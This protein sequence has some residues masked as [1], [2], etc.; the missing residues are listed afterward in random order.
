[1]MSSTQLKLLFYKV[2]YIFL[3][4]S[5]TLVSFNVHGQMSN[6]ADALND[7]N[8]YY[9]TS[10]ITVSNLN[11]TGNTDGCVAG[12]IST[13]A[14]N[15]F[16]DRIK[17]FRRLVGVS[18]NV[19][20]DNTKNNK[21]QEAALIM[22]ANNSL[23]HFPP[24]SWDCYNADG[25]EAAGK[26]NLH[27][28][29]IS[30]FNPINSYISDH[31]TG[32]E[33]VGHRR[34]IFYSKATE[35]GIGQ[36]TTANSMWVIQDSSTPA[37]Y[38][39]YIA[40]PPNG[41]IPNHL[42]FERWSFGIPN[43]NFSNASVRVK[44]QNNNELDVDIIY[45]SGPIYADNTIVF[46]P[47]GII[48]NSMDDIEYEITISNIAGASS[49][50]YTYTTRLFD[51]QIDQLDGSCN[52]SDGP[53]TGTYNSTFDFKAVNFIEAPDAGNQM[54]ALGNSD[55]VI[56]A[57]NYI[58]LNPGFLSE[59]GS[60]VTIEI[61]DCAD[62]MFIEGETNTKIKLDKNVAETRTGNPLRLKVF[63]SEDLF[64]SELK[65]LQD[66]E[67]QISPN[68]F[69]EFVNVSYKLHSDQL[70]SLI[71]YST[72]GKL[73]KKIEENI[74]RKSGTHSVRISDLELSK[75]IYLLQLSTQENG[76]LEELI[77]L[78]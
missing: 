47:S 11:W 14:K 58:E 61:D 32:N 67:F 6:R 31:H 49:N 56:N 57:G 3:F 42:A 72:E 20:L 8:N 7:Y 78:Q 29:N 63:G 37:I 62:Q 9:L 36:T 34:W 44:D 33:P 10:E 48:T 52:L 53:L 43:A 65:S 70:V 77:I 26:G 50:Q 75:G 30:L 46:E 21:C 27:I 28:G 66:N 16:L 2:R 13:S 4:L 12:S 35:F 24:S 38:N 41:Y 22:D 19:T 74:F 45:K 18:D 71:I 17:Y 1:M 64:N 23:N 54:S 73:V 60:N 25:A 15:K 40:Y 5:I 69:A 68:P 39:E 59:Y 55:I 76:M 51:P